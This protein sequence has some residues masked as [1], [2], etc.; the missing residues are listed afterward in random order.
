MTPGRTSGALVDGLA[1]AMGL[2]AW[3]GTATPAPAWL[4]DELSC[5]WRAAQD[6]AAAAYEHWRLAPGR[7]GYAVYRA[8]Q[9]RADAAQTVLHGASRAAVA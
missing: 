9:D 3:R 1:R 6:E 2:G 8:S 7:D 5:A 4:L